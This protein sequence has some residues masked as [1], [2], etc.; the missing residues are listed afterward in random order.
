MHDDFFNQSSFATH[1]IGKWRGVVKVCDDAPLELL[2]P[3]GCGVQTWAGAVL[4]VFRMKPGQTLAVFGSGSLGLSAVM[5]A[6]IAGAGRIIAVDVS[7]SVDETECQLQ[8]QGH[9]TAFRDPEVHNAIR[10]GMLRR[11]AVAYVEWAGLGH[12]EIVADWFVITDKQSAEH[13]TDKLNRGFPS[14][15]TRTAISG[16]IDFGVAWLEDNKYEGTRRVIDVS[17]DGPNNGGTLVTVAREK[18][19]A[20]GITV[21]GLP[22]LDD[23]GGFYTRYNIGRS[24]PLLP[25]LRDRRPRLMISRDNPRYRRRPSLPARPGRNRVNSGG[26]LWS[27]RSPFYRL[28][29]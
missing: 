18:A 29:G 11:I 22:I 10:S 25:R 7:R 27:R 5:A 12:R 1:A 15:A 16:D 20:A 13:F 3:L 23:G 21:N 4:N 19:V 9:V 28:P 26:F 8:R 14:S 17:G 24:R 2:G 6:R